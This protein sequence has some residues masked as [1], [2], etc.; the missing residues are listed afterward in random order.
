MDR[1]GNF[2][3]QVV[4][5]G[6]LGVAALLVAAC[7]GGG[8]VDVGSGQTPDPASVD[9]PIFYVK[10]TIPMNSDDLRQMRDT[11][12]DADLFKRDRASPGAPETNVTDRVTGTDRW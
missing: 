5:R 3:A 12:D 10:R 6:T 7:S 11:V 2:A 9:F 1:Q 4:T 8:S